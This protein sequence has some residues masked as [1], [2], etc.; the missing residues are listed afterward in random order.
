[1]IE[2][3]PRSKKP[4]C[5]DI[6]SE[7]RKDLLLLAR[8]LKEQREA[9]EFK[10][11]LCEKKAK[12]SQKQLAAGEAGYQEQ[13]QSWEARK[14]AARASRK[15]RDDESVVTSNSGFESFLADSGA[16]CR[17]TEGTFS[18]SSGYARTSSS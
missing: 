9:H 4:V 5:Y 2:V 3:D 15:K 17:S 11:Y 10:S 18:I 12:E 16:L 14:A 13:L 6:P 7:V 1:M 8:R